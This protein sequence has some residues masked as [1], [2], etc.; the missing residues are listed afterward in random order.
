MRARFVLLSLVALSACSNQPDEP[1]AP[2]DRSAV[3][4]ASTDDTPSLDVAADPRD[5]ALA[6]VASTDELMGH[7]S[8]GRGELLAEFVLPTSVSEQALALDDA[9]QRLAETLDVPAERLTW[10]EAPLTAQVS[11]RGDES[12][13]VAVWTVSVLGAPAS[14]PP[15][16]VWRTVH[17][18]LAL[19]DGRW[20]VASATAD[21]GPTPTSNELAL[22]PSW[23]DFAEVAGWEPVVKSE[24]MS[25][26]A[27][28]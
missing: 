26:G 24:P 25:A 4:G 9:A 22:Q 21:S 23:S 17:V 28:R 7:S 18:E 3:T 1:R 27:D 6:Y 20:L 13:S 14:G 15:Q 16:V 8:I 2:D 5:A 12:A 10:V 11:D 19:D